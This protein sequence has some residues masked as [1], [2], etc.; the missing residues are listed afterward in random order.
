MHDV[1]RFEVCLEL[2]IVQHS[3]CVVQLRQC[4]WCRLVVTQYKA[5]VC[6]AM[7]CT[8]GSKCGDDV[9]VLG[10]PLKERALAEKDGRAAG[11]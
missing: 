9:K 3:A 2:A 4:A 11:R 10:F 8:F 7:Q 6:A 1:G 5:L